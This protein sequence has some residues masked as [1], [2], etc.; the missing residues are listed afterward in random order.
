MSERKASSKK[1]E[2]SSSSDDYKEE[3]SKREKDLKKSAK[4]EQYL[5]VDKKEKRKS[6]IDLAALLSPRQETTSDSG[7]P[8]LEGELYKYAGSFKGMRFQADCWFQMQ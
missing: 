3:G 4:K 6:K 5:K 7:L 8:S 1:P 2:V